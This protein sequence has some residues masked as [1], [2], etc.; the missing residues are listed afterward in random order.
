MTFYRDAWNKP[1][2]IPNR[3]ELTYLPENDDAHRVRMRLIRKSDEAVVWEGHFAREDF[4]NF[5][6][7]ALNIVKVMAPERIVV[8]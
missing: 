2:D 5:A 7:V 1:P 8:S 4:L 6:A 3:W